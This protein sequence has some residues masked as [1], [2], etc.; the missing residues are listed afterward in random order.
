MVNYEV[1]LNN[2]IHTV[3]AR[4]AFNAAEDFMKLSKLNGLIHSVRVENPIL[5]NGIF[6]SRMSFATDISKQRLFVVWPV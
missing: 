5:R 4:N 3:T 2:Q 6:L 1:T